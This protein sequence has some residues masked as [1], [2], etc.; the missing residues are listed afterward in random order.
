MTIKDLLDASGMS[1]ADLSRF[2]NAPYRTVQDWKLG[3]RQCPIYVIELIYY[4]L[5]NEGYIK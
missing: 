2:I 3:N 4:K 5:K 1:T